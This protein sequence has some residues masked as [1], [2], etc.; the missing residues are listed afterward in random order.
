MSEMAALTLVGL[1]VFLF[2]FILVLYVT[3]NFFNQIT[4]SFK[5]IQSKF[6]SY[7]EEAWNK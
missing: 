1:V 5:E 4:A 2:V 6:R 7:A 3:F